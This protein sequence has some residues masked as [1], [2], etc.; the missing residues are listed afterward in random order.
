MLKDEPE[1]LTHLA[2]TP[3]DAC[4]SLEGGSFF[5]D[6]L[7]DFML[8]SNYCPLLSDDPLDDPRLS[9]KPRPGSKVY[10]YRDADPIASAVGA[11]PN[12]RLAR[13]LSPSMSPTLSPELAKVCLLGT[14]QRSHHVR[15]HK[16]RRLQ[17]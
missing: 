7:D 13:M 10:L 4:I 8:D 12:D 17:V 9:D 14:W 2:P 3:G 16:K 6:M 15:M 1:D 5:N 11:S